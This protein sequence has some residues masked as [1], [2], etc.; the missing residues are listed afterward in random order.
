MSRYSL[1]DRR[2]VGLRPLAQRGH[3]LRVA[4]VA[5]LQAPAKCYSHPEFHVLV[6][7]VRQ[8]RELERPVIVMLGGHPIR[9]KAKGTGLFELH[10]HKT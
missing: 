3:D 9:A 10:P 5:P 2:G 8:A 4:N 6:D 7:A 1:F